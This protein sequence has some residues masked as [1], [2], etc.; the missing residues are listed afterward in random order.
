MADM[1]VALLGT[2]AVVLAVKAHDSPRDRWLVPAIAAVLGLGFAAKGPIAVLL[3]GLALCALA[4]A[5]GRK[6]APLALVPVLLALALFALLG[7]GWFV[8]VSLRLGLEPLRYFF[9]SENLARFSGSTYDSG[10]GPAYYILTY[11]TQGAP[12]SLLLIPAVVQVLRSRERESGQDARWLV[13]ALLLMV[14]PL[15]LS[16]G[17]IDYYLLPLYP[18]A[19]ALIGVSLAAPESAGALRWCRSI[20]VLAGVAALVAVAAFAPKLPPAW[21]PAAPLRVASIA[22]ALVAALAL[23]WV[24]WR[25]RRDR[26][27]AVLAASGAVLFG[28]YVYVWA[29]AFARGQGNRRVIN[30]VQ[31]EYAYRRDAG[32]VLCDDPTRV[33]RDVIF[34]SSIPTHDRCDLWAP[35]SSREAYLLLMSERE[36]GTLKRHPRLRLVRAYR[37]VPADALGLRS[38]LRRQRLQ[39]LYLAANYTTID[40][41]AKKTERIRRREQRQRE[42]KWRREREQREA[43]RPGGTPSGQPS[44]LS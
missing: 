2:L 19:A 41:V 13:W 11:L 25:P 20:A 4:W 39:K 1:P 34:W 29:P 43:A 21:L 7:F 35:A 9:L 16:R 12:W 33:H 23:A 44:P 18:L 6:A 22:A 17:K 24:A 28:I 40:P 26:L 15:S 30:D 14:V 38:A 5:K 42:E 32:L 10:R 8:A 3:P 31:R 37:Y 36:W 27:V